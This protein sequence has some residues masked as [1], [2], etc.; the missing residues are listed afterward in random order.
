MEGIRLRAADDLSV[1]GKVCKE[2]GMDT[3]AHTERT[4]KGISPYPAPGRSH[5]RCDLLRTG[6]RDLRLSFPS[7]QEKSLCQGST[8]RI[9]RGIP[10]GTESVGGKGVYDPGYCLRRQARRETDLQ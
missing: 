6:L 7:S 9:R 10:G 5:R 2:Q 3:A 8:Y 1:I 4:E